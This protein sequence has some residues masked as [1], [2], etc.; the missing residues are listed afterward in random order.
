MGNK[1]QF[2]L[3]LMVSMWNLNAQTIKFEHYN[4]QNG[5]S[6]NSVRHIIQ[7]D[8]GFLWLGTFSGLNRFDGYEFKTYTS[9]S[10]LNNTIP[11]DDITDLELDKESNQ[12]WI[13]TRKG[14]VLYQLDTHTFRTFLP[15]V[16]DP[17]ALQD[18]EIRSVHVDRFKQV[19]VGTKDNGL[20][21]YNPKTHNFKKV[22]LEGFDY[23]KEIIEDSRGF[24]WLASY[25]TAGIAKISLDNTGDIAQIR[26]YTLEVPE[27]TETN[28]YVNFIYEDHKSDIFVGS[29][30]GL[31]KLEEQTD[32]FK[33]LYLKD[34]KVRDK[35]GPY[36]ISVARAPNGEY[37]LG[38]L[39]G[40]L[41]VDKLEDIILQEYRWYYSE[42]SDD[43]SLADNLVAA[44]YFD[45][46]GV[47]WIGTEDGLEKYDPYNNQFNYNSDISQYIGNQVPRIRGF[48]KT[49]DSRIIVATRHNGLFIS[50]NGRYIPL[51]NN[52]KDI[53]SIFTIDGNIFYCGLWEGHILRYDYSSGKASVIDVGFSRSPILSF[54]DL[55]NEKMMVG[56]H[57]EGAVIINT[58]T[59]SPINGM[60]IL[61]PSRPINKCVVDKKGTIWFATQTGVIRF[62]QE[63]GNTHVYDTDLDE[64]IGLSHE[65]VSDITIDPSGKIWAATRKGLDYYDPDLD[66]FVPVME[67]TELKNSWITDVVSDTNGALW[68]NMNN[69]RIAQYKTQSNELKIY[70]TDSGNRL[71]VFSTTG[72]YYAD[73]SH[74]YLGGKNEIISFSPAHIKDNDISPAPLIT[75]IKIQNT[76]LEVGSFLND[77][78]VLTSD[79]NLSRE[80]VLENVNKNFSL[81][82]S[83][84][85]YTSERFNKYSYRLVGFDKG[86]NT[87]DIRQR[88][89]Q[90]TNLFF[91]DYN[92]EVKSMNSHGIWSDVSSY[93]IK[94]LPPF[95]LTYQS[96]IILILLLSLLFYMVRKQM[97]ARLGLK[98]Q[99]LLEKVKRER[100]EKLNNEKLKFFTNISHELRTPLTLILGPAK[101]LIEEGKESGNQ[102]QQSRFNLIHQN[103]NRLLNLVNQVLDFRRAQSGE[104]QLKV[105]KTNIFQRTTNTFRSFQELADDKKI[106]FNIVCDNQEMEGYLDWDKYDKI[107]YNLLSNA[108]KFTHQYGQVD[109]FV[110]THL[111]NDGQILIVEVSDDGIGIPPE[112]Q[113]KIFSRFFQASNSKENNTGSGI[114]LSLV[115]ALVELHKGTIEVESELEK[116]STFT[117][118]IPISKKAYSADEIFE[119][120]KPDAHEES[121]QLLTAK[122]IIQS[123]H[124]KER[125]LIIEDNIELRNYLVEYLSDHYKVFEAENGKVGL[126]QCRKVKPVLCIADI[127]MPEMDGLEFCRILKNDD[128]ISHVPVILLTALSDSDDKIRGYSSGADGYLVKPFEPSLLKTRIENI[129]KSRMELK[130]KFSVEVDSEVTTLTHSP[131]DEMFMENLTQLIKDDMS[132]LDL[133]TTFLCHELGMS[134]SKLYRKIKE[135]TDLAPNEFIRTIR[136]KKAAHLLNTKK[137][138][139]SE[140]TVLVGFNDPLYFSRCFKKQFG[141]PPS[142]LIK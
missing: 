26:E 19:W 122:K 137:Y 106:N 67:P 34:S 16:N 126:E 51:F 59:L 135:I 33:N 1:L 32:S 99:L 9:S 48:A 56:A 101:Q 11:D 93:Q 102:F 75:N 3:A 8:Q 28:P 64:N 133:N 7:D 30:R 76:D 14:L 118:K 13:G 66:D 95:W 103:A 115:W 58:E 42:L 62:D 117:L 22:V 29:R 17:N 84:P 109:L 71:D 83:S 97:K 114:G 2:L 23:I 36:F 138:N 63:N 87:V 55:G 141:Y 124:L 123:T 35:L 96:L 15:N 112:S 130:N 43:D 139:V 5:L 52:Q 127:M 90:Y 68:L 119:V 134:S 85:S 72:F 21:I 88:T 120:V 57:G 50:D 70:Y 80:L 38:T 79:I 105:T 110:N 132:N 136:L 142:N 94:I 131:A 129:I 121:P 104:L 20:F 78:Q 140:V 41:V 47:L 100:D 107:L 18:G 6:H 111:E 89:V 24:I 40:I 91:G 4:D 27:S 113:A 45:A 73:D 60:G 125:I 46:S 81:T 108:L 44:L 77:Q 92:F 37:W 31:Y 10:E 54:A 61:L 69:N 53:A 86:W 65:N 74:I 49:K 25:G 98:H 128:D 82:F 39:G 12:L 116:G